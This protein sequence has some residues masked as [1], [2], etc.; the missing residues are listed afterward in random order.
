MTFQFKLK[1]KGG[2][3]RG[4]RNICGNETIGAKH[5]G[6]KLKVGMGQ[7]VCKKEGHGLV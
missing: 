4:Y 1:R 5:V 6:L 3:K 2:K 7:G